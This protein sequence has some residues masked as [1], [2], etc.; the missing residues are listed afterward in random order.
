MSSEDIQ[1]KPKK[2]RR[3]KSKKE[4]PKRA[5]SAYLFFAQ[6]T[7]PQLKA[8]NPDMPFLTIGSE[9]GKLWAKLPPCE[10]A[11]Y[12]ELASIDKARWN[13]E[14]ASF[15]PTT[16]STGREKTPKTRPPKPKIPSGADLFKKM[17]RAELKNNGST[18]PATTLNAEVLKMWKALSEEE[19]APYNKM[20]E[21]ARSSMDMK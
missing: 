8:E 5:V 14:K 18:L 19:K 2:T 16:L 11:H 3:A 13:A 20:A 9:L 17:K 15:M 21:E 10:K 6:A 4:G 1:E 12:E 7:R